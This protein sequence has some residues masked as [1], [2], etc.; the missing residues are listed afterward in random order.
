MSRKIRK[1]VV[2]DVEC[3]GQFG[4]YCQRYGSDQQPEDVFIERCFLFKQKD[5]GTDENQRD[6]IFA[7]LFEPCQSKTF[8]KTVGKNVPVKNGPQDKGR[9]QNIRE[10]HETLFYVSDNE[11]RRNQKR[12]TLH[13]PR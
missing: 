6:Q 7:D 11:N 8:N 10:K 12:N 9:R 3:K 5:N 2:A 13:I 1:S 4:T